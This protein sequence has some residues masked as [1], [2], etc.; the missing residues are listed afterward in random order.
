VNVELLGDFVVQLLLLLPLLSSFFPSYHHQLLWNPHDKYS[1]FILVGDK[2]IAKVS[3]Q[4][5]QL[6]REKPISSYTKV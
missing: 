4:L 3:H 6:H 1:F 2:G 5:L